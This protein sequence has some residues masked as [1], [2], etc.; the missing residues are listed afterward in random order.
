MPGTW[1][2]VRS[3]N[4]SGQTDDSYCNNFISS[5]IHGNVGSSFYKILTTPQPWATFSND[6]FDSK[7]AAEAGGKP[8]T[9]HT[10][11]GFHDNIHGWVGQGKLRGGSGHMAFPQYAAFDPI[12]WYVSALCLS[13][14][15]ITDHLL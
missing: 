13:F 2:T 8:H 3:P 12:F 9:D 14:R 7:A 11:E 4:S 1:H 15:K 6:V 5:H 10:L